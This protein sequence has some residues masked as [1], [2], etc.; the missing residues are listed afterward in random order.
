MLIV[1]NRVVVSGGRNI[2]DA[3]YGLSDGY[4]FFDLDLLAVGPVVPP[5][6]TMFDRYWN[7]PQAAPGRICYRN[8]SADDIP[9]LTAERQRALRASSLSEIVPVEPAEW[10]DRF[11]MAIETMVPGVAEVRVHL[12]HLQKKYKS[13]AIVLLFDNSPKFYLT[14][15]LM[16]TMIM[17]MTITMIKG[18]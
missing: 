11:A 4:N 1:D 6:S 7:S 14:S 9:R 8:A 16:M 10:D 13:D 15:S 5:T 2:A 17:I 12:R 3:Y 18:R